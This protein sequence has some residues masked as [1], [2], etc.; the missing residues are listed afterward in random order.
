MLENHS[1]K[2]V[3]GLFY[4]GTPWYEIRVGSSRCVPI[5]CRVASMEKRCFV[6]RNRKAL[7]VRPGI[8]GRWLGLALVVGSL[9]EVL[10]VS[11]DPLWGS[12][13]RLGSLLGSLWDVL[14]AS[15]RVL[16]VSWEAFGELLGVSGRRFGGSW[17]PLD[18]WRSSQRWWR[19]LLRFLSLLCYSYYIVE[20]A[21]GPGLTSPLPL[22][23]LVG[24]QWT[25]HNVIFLLL[26]FAIRIHLDLDMRIYDIL[27]LDFDFGSW[28]DL[29]FQTFVKSIKK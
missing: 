20:S 14:G 22:P 9:S 15:W 19:D 1:T 28:T 17:A 26:S 2:F 4:V 23:A 7:D 5:L 3:Q 8:S 24:S 10:G 29:V 18:M 27:L 21:G 25:R 6:W 12:R 11:W 13:R 16:G